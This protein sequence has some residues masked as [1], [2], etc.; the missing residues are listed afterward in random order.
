MAVYLHMPVS[1]FVLLYLRWNSTDVESHLCSLNE[2]GH[3]GLQKTHL[4]M[5]W[6]FPGLHSVKICFK[7][8]WK[9]LCL[10][11]YWHRPRQTAER[12]TWLKLPRVLWSHRWSGLRRPGRVCA[13]WKLRFERG[14]CDEI[15]GTPL[16]TDRWD[17]ALWIWVTCLQRLA[18][19]LLFHYEN[20]TISWKN[21]QDASSNETAQM[22]SLRKHRDKGCFPLT[23]DVDD[24]TENVEQNW[25]MCSHGM[26]TKL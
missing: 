17:R 2:E 10:Q 16:F 18:V 4:W 24:T 26:A 13:I 8:T 12:P 19:L 3:L 6:S 14:K 5:R 7:S 22:L 23:K 11:K 25:H 20:C 1:Q 9:L 21:C 15:V